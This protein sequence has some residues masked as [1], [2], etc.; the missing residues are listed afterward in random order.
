MPAL[1]RWEYFAWAALG[2][3]LVAALAAWAGHA[4]FFDGAGGAADPPFAQFYPSPVSADFT[5]SAD[6]TYRF[7][8]ETAAASVAVT[9]PAPGPDRPGA[10]YLWMTAEGEPGPPVCPGLHTYP[11]TLVRHYAAGS[12]VTLVPCRLVDPA[13]D[14]DD[15]TPPPTLP[16][17]AADLV[18]VELRSALKESVLLQR[19]EIV[20]DE[21]LDED[22]RATPVVLD[23]PTS[24]PRVREDVAS[25]P[26]E[27]RLFRS[28]TALTVQWTAVD[29]A[30]AYALE[31]KLCPFDDCSQSEWLLA[32]RVP[33]SGE[34][35][36]SH[37]DHSIDLDANP[38]NWYRYRL[39]TLREDFASPWSPVLLT[40]RH[41]SYSNADER[42]VVELPTSLAEG[43]EVVIYRRV[44][45]GNY[46]FASVA[47][48]GTD[49]T[50]LEWADLDPAIV[51][52]DGSY[53]V[54][55]VCYRAELKNVDHPT[56]ASV[57]AYGLQWPLDN[58]DVDDVSY[59]CVPASHDLALNMD[60]DRSSLYLQWRRPPARVRGRDFLR[61]DLRMWMRPVADHAMAQL[62]TIADDRRAL[63]TDSPYTFTILERGADRLQV[64]VYVLGILHTQI[65]LDGGYRVDA[66]INA[67]YADDVAL[68]ASQRYCVGP[69]D[70]YTPTPLATGTAVPPPPSMRVANLVLHSCSYRSADDE[71]ELNIHWDPAL[72]VTLDGM[73]TNYEVTLSGAQGNST[74][75]HTST[76]ASLHY[77]LN[78]A[79]PRTVDAW[80][81][82]VYEN[83]MGQVVATDQSNVVTCATASP[84]TATPTPTPEPTPTP[85]ATA[86]PTPTP[87]PGQRP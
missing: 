55:G 50:S 56:E 47:T 39:R 25:L 6:T 10:A 85:T 3:A 82:A 69:V 43:G 44:G 28:A 34:S 84:A 27:L 46:R 59:N 21:T 38:A 51:A 45:G 80:V 58:P 73:L 8:L 54:S 32:A 53:R 26:V 48:P 78:G 83:D 13:P 63:L 15:V 68:R 35:W 74:T 5:W 71:L 87:T 20:L 4:L 61:Y 11:E 22:A 41:V 36:E 18:V 81:R 33:A 76:S 65:Y 77:H 30:D 1:V 40:P 16:P 42:V 31:R 79:L 67:H 75:A 70:R 17:D 72:A 14:D 52:D 49:V 37:L 64:P 62:A 86:T 9:L 12:V 24:T 60:C 7:R 29:R 66:A 57:A 2:L 19:Y 23:R